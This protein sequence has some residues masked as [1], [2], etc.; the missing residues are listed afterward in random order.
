MRALMLFLTAAFAITAVPASAQ[1]AG[2]RQT[3]EFVMAAAQSDTFEIMEAQ[4]AL[5]QS[6]DPQVRNFA[7]MMIDAH[8][9][10]SQAL[11]EAA[12]RAGLKPPA[13]AMSSDQAAMLS[14]LQSLRGPEFDRMYARQQALA[15]RAAL[16]TEQNYAASGDQSDVRSAA[17]SAVPIITSHLQMA[18]QLQAQ[19]GG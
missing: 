7:Q 16:T 4:T 14:A 12:S 15:H 17:T 2:S 10:T 3:R 9:K 19:G 8:T 1:E 18:E 11:T 5:A 6:T 13:K